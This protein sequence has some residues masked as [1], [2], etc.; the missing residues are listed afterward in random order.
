VELFRF[1]GE[2]TGNGEF[3][4]DI[5]GI[6]ITGSGLVFVSDDGNHR[7]QV[8]NESGGYLYQFGNTGSGDQ[9]L[10][11]AR[12]LAATSDGTVVVADEWAFALKEFA[13]TGTGATFVDKL[14]GGLPPL[15]GVN[16]PRGM[17]VDPST[18]ALYA[19]DWWN[20]RIEKFDAAGNFVTAWGQRG[21]KAEPGSI[22]FAWDVAVNP[23]NGNVYVANRESHEIEVFSSTGA[24]VTRWGYRGTTDGKFS[25]PQ[26]VAFDPT[27]GTLLVADSG[28]NRIQRFAILASGKGSWIASYG[29][30]GTAPGQFA[31][32]TGIDVA[33]DG[34]IW[35]ADTQNDRIQQ[36]NP[37]TGV[38]TAYTVASGDSTNFKSPW[39]VTVAPDGEIWV[40]DTGLDRLVR[41]TSSGVWLST[42]DAGSLGIASMDGPFTVEFGPSGRIYASVVWNNR[43]LHLA[44]S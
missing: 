10:T 6:D 17:D 14:F 16:S 8:F 43:I 29:S 27:N 42:A 20:Q 36:R 31:T 37:S 9:F 26:G 25:F 15:P 4:G 18:G 40:A 32:P 38:W 34:T 1:G 24:Y 13:Y 21:T 41:M 7:V 19:V 2:G 23:A 11:D 44:A 33:P 3:M 12:G 28:N 39:G 5:R 35:V 22:N 30:A